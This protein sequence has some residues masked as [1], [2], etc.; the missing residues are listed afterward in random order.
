SFGN[1]ELGPIPPGN[2]EHGTAG[3]GLLYR[4]QIV[5][6]EHVLVLAVLQQS[7]HHSRTA[8]HRVPTLSRKPRGG[9]FSTAFLRFGAGLDLPVCYGSCGPGAAIYTGGHESTF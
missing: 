3:V 4:T 9:N 7:C 5:A 1:S 6:V 2:H 8:A